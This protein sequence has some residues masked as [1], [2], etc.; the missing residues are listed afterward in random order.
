MAQPSFSRP[1]RVWLLDELRGLS[2]LLMVLYHAGYDLIYIFGVHIPFFH[3][4][5]LNL[6]QSLFAGLFILISGCCCRLSRSN[7][8]RGAAVLA[9]GLGMTLVT[10]LFLPDQLILFGILHLLGAS[11]LLFALLRPLL[12]PVPVPLGVLLTASLFAATWL[13]PRESLGFFGIAFFDLPKELF[14]YSW[15]FPFGFTAPGF[16]SSDYFPLMPWF[17]LFLCGSYLGIPI[18]EKR[19][20]AFFYKRHIPF[21]SLAGRYTIWI[22]LLHQPVVYGVLLVFFTLTGL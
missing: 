15:L 1:D 21:L 11:M 22:Y 16:S 14:T 4:S 9:L 19:F 10:W 13:L 6:L 18:R 20:P 3:S 12:D 5:F 7:L 17:F 2:I 8:A